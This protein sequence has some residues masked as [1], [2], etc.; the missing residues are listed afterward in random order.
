ME[1]EPIKSYLHELADAAERILLL[2]GPSALFSVILPIGCISSAAKRCLSLISMPAM[3]C[4]SLPP[5]P[6]LLPTP[7][8]SRLFLIFYRLLSASTV[9]RRWCVLATRGLI[10]SRPN[11]WYM[12]WAMSAF[13]LLK[14]AISALISLPWKKAV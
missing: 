3:S 13:G 1:P 2:Q 11:L 9:L 7:I 14:K 4:V 12:L 10:I 6:T 8:L 5:S